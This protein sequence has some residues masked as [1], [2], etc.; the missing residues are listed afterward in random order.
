MCDFEKI[1]YETSKIEFIC[2]KC[3]YQLKCNLLS[4][5]TNRTKNTSF[6]YTKILFDISFKRKMILASYYYQLQIELRNKIIIDIPVKKSIVKFND[7]P[8]VIL[9]YDYCEFN[10]KSVKEPVLLS[11]NYHR[12]PI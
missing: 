9:I 7:N 12:L 11:I 3:E 1:I 4:A 2:I 8:D 10:L 6:N 5:E